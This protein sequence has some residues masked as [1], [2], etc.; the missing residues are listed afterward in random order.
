MGGSGPL[1]GIRVIDLTHLIAGPY[2]TM[3]MADAGATVIKVEPPWGD[4][5]RLRGARR[6]VGGDA[7][8]SGFLVAHNAG[9]Q[10]I[11]L[12][13][14]SPAGRDVLSD[15]LAGA[16]VLVENFAPGV[17]DHLGLGID[18]LHR[19][20]PRL[21]TASISLFDGTSGDS[22]FARPGL[23]IV[24]EAESGLVS[25]RPGADGR[26]VSFGFPLGDVASGLTAFAG[27]TTALLERTQTGRG[28]HVDVSMVRTLVSFNAAALSGFALAGGEDESIRTVPYGYYPTADGYV[29]VGINVDH[30]WRRFT[31][32]IG[33]SELGNDPR[34]ACY[35]ERDQRADEVNEIVEVWTRSR[36]SS[37]V[38]AALTEAGIP[39][40]QVRS[41]ASLAD[42]PDSHLL[43]AVNDGIGGTVRLPRNP[44]GFE[45]ETRTVPRLGEHTA[46]V[47][48]DLG[49][50][51][52]RVTRLSAGGAF[53]PSA[54]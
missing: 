16:D 23:A 24:A 44:M 47:L 18:S 40:G 28:R 53:G 26:P 12:D 32:A 21:I 2:C 1:A 43:R 33:R 49:Y 45:R 30:L 20:H 25:M 8:V 3:L 6:S 38:V 46:T 7:H 10:S 19:D 50:S 31:V 29:A 35:S 52:E 14:K 13:L 34:Y 9:K 11:V 48:R 42:D 5:A 39:C 37:Y 17:L 51:E 27:I 15:L 4:S 41:L 22:D 54:D 36:T